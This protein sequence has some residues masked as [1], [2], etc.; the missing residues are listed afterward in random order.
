LLGCTL[1]FIS[2]K[3]FCCFTGR[4]TPAVTLLQQHFFNSGRAG[5]VQ[6]PSIATV[7]VPWS[8]G[9]GRTHY[10]QVDH[11]WGWGQGGTT[12]ICIAWLVCSCQHQHAGLHMQL[13]LCGHDHLAIL[14]NKE[15]NS[16]RGLMDERNVMCTLG[17]RVLN[18]C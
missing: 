8:A 13:G 17:I 3:W 6:R 11:R 9:C 1:L 18:R 4:P 10:P 14:T 16:C 7:E 12:V 15:T 2:R 5:F